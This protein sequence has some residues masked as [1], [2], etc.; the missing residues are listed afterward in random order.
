MFDMRAEALKADDIPGWSVT[1]SNLE[2][3]NE[4]TKILDED[5]RQ[6]AL[7]VGNTVG[8]ASEGITTYEQFEAQRV[9]AR[10]G[11][12]MALHARFHTSSKPP[13]EAQLG[14]AEVFTNAFLLDAPLLYMHNNDYGWWEIEEKLQMARKK[15]LN[16]WSEHYPYAAGSSAISADLFKPEAVEGMLGLKY[17][18]VMFDPVQDKYL[19]KEEYLQV[20]RE[21]PSRIVI[22]FNPPRRKWMEHW[23]RMP[24][25]VVAADSMWS[26]DPSQNWDTDPAEY[27]GHPRTSGTH[28]KSLRM[29]REAGRAADVHPGAAQLLVR[30]P[31][32]RHGPGTDEDPRPDAGRNGR[33]HHHLRSRDGRRR[34]GLQEGHERPAA[35]GPAPRDR[36]WAVRQ[37]GRQGHECVCRAADPV[38]R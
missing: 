18:E 23:L 9:A 4:I 28:T 6:G 12:P 30:P 10:Y 14:F 15:G 35:Q 33:R 24:H 27:L 8:Y 26:T 32:G 2:Q 22:G 1:V 19:T 29:A 38:S 7:C 36:Q 31:P 3:I 25:M 11:R 13:T 34:V 17:E 20:V 21:D 37:E 5:L 16:M